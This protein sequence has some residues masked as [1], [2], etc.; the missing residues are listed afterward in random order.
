MGVAIPASATA[1]TVTAPHYTMHVGDVVPPC[2]IQV[3]NG[4]TQVGAGSAIFSTPPTC[5]IGA[6]SAS[7]VGTYTVTVNAGTLVS[8][9]DTATYTNSSIAVIAADGIGAKLTNGK[10]Y[11]SGFSSSPNFPA[12]DVTNNGI[13][14]LVG[15]CVTDNTIAINRLFGLGRN[16]STDTVTITGGTTVTLTSGT[17]FTGLVAG[18]IVKVMGNPNTI[19]SVTSATVLVL[20]N[21]VTNGTGQ[22]IELPWWNVST[23]GTTVTAN[24][25]TSFLSI[26]AVYIGATNL[27]VIIAGV[28]YHISSV[29]DATHMVLF[30]APPTLTGVDL[31]LGSTNQNPTGAQPQNWYFPP[32][33]YATSQQINQPGEFFHYFGSGPQ[34]S[35]FY[36]LP[37]SV[38]FN[39]GT[40]AV[41]WFNPASVGAGGSG[42]NSNFHE[43]IYNMGFRV[44]VGNPNAEIVTTEMSNA[45]AYKNVQL[46]SDDSLCK[47]GLN[48]SRAAPGPGIIKNVAIYG[49]TTA[50]QSN[51]PE[52]LMTF[53]NITT[54][55]QTA[56]TGAFDHSSIRTS[57]R[58]WLS[59]NPGTVIH[60]YGSSGS[61]TAI[62]DSEFLNGNSANPA[63]AV[64]SNSFAYVRNL[65]VSGYTTSDAD[66]GT[67]TT[68]NTTGNITQVW[69]GPAKTIFNTAQTP[70]S[71]H[72]PENETPVATDPA[73]STWTELGPSVSTWCAS[74]TGSTSTTVYAPPGQY[75]GSSFTCTIPDTVN[76]LQFYQAMRGSATYTMTFNVAG[77]SATPLVIDDC[78]YESCIINHTGSR[79]VVLV[80][81]TIDEYLTATGTG[82]LYIEDD[83]M[84][85][86]SQ[87]GIILQPSQHVWARQLDYE[88]GSQPKVT[89]NGC[90]LWILG[91]KTEQSTPN[92]ILTG[93]A[94]AEIFNSFF[95]QNAAVGSTNAPVYLTDSSIF[96]GTWIKVDTAGRGMPNWVNETQNGITN[97][98]PTPSIQ[99]SVSLPMFYSFGAT[100]ITS[101]TVS[102]MGRIRKSGNIKVF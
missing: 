101:S 33:C 95:Y 90:T 68:V 83:S 23:S 38:A 6:T 82:D 69:T 53:E 52:F 44:G 78:P 56:S 27:G 64:A 34:T 102:T 50:I 28:L 70:D 66:T 91:Y 54:E 7:A 96:F 14:D 75:F 25:G 86:P 10:T 72:L 47:T 40:S 92:L 99:N 32:G 71:L 94:K 35:Y 42:G 93:H 36:L 2:I 48:L 62:L 16:T 76:H 12:L 60:L 88:T 73:Q 15:D 5:S 67:G 39:T 18:G 49:C 4:T 41:Q 87:T 24:N 77:T 13:A 29:T 81:S 61:S 11:P 26:P 63:I 43:F 1:Y 65:T 59:D 21:P 98:L 80:D 74:I 19:A 55:G 58:H 46:W 57:F 51:Q 89:C 100:T 17:Q 97:S 31:L 85:Y 20:T 8:G 79:T 30:A 45:G 9:S 22:Y 37:N 84:G 3:L